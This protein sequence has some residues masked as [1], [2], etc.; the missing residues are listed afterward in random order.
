MILNVSSTFNENEECCSRQFA[1]DRVW[2]FHNSRGYYVSKNSSNPW[3]MMTFDEEILLEKVIITNSWLELKA[4]QGTFQNITV[5]AGLDLIPRPPDGEQISENEECVCNEKSNDT[6]P[7][8]KEYWFKCISTVEAKI[9]TIQRIDDKK[10]I[11]VF[12]E[13]EIIGKGKCS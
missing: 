8:G 1:I 10:V 13:V 9:I 7:M 4:N 12:D 3:F 2:S 11:L 5:R 6:S